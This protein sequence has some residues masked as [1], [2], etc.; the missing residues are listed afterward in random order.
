MP[1][2]R[3]RWDADASPTVRARVDAQLAALRLR[4]HG[5]GVGEE[6]AQRAFLAAEIGRYL[7]RKTDNPEKL[8]EPLPAPPGQPI[9]SPLGTL[10]ETDGVQTINLGGCTWGG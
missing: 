10:G 9:G 2:P 4:L 6:G 5:A 8:P 3:P 7:D 1:T